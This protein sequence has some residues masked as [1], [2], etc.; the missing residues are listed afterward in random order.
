MLLGSANGT[1]PTPTLRKLPVVVLKTPDGHIIN[2]NGKHLAQPPESHP[3]KPNTDPNE[4]GA[5]AH[6]QPESHAANVQGNALAQQ[7]S[8]AQTLHDMDGPL[9]STS[10]SNSTLTRTPFRKS[11]PD[12]SQATLPSQEA[13]SAT[14]ATTPGPTTPSATQTP[15]LSAALASSR[16]AF[17]T[18]L[19][20]LRMIGRAVGQTGIDATE[21]GKV[22]L[23]DL[24]TWMSFNRDAFADPSWLLSLSGSDPGQP[25]DFGP[26]NLLHARD[27]EVHR[28]GMAL[29]NTSNEDFIIRDAVIL[30]P[31]PDFTI[32]PGP[33]NH[34]LVKAMSGSYIP[35]NAHVGQRNA[36]GRVDATLCVLLDKVSPP[37]AADAPT[38]HKR[39]PLLVMQSIKILYTDGMSLSALA[40][41]FVPQR[42]QLA[43]TSETP[44]DRIWESPPPPASND[45]RFWLQNNHATISAERIDSLLEMPVVPDVGPMPK[46]ASRLPLDRHTFS[47]HF[48]TSLRYEKSAIETIYR[49]CT[50]FDP[51]FTPYAR[52]APGEMPDPW[53]RS[54]WKLKVPGIAEGRPPLQRGNPVW[55][56][57]LVPMDLVND[58]GEIVYDFW[59]LRGH[60]AGLV[61]AS[62][63]V[64]L[65]LPMDLPD[66]LE[67]IVIFPVPPD[68][69]SAH[70]KAL[71][72]VESSS[73]S[74]NED[75]QGLRSFLF[76]R[77]SD[78]NMLPPNVPLGP[79]TLTSKFLDP[80]LNLDQQMAVE[81]GVRGDYGD[82]VFAINGGPGT[83]KT[84]TA[85]EFVRQTIAMH[86][87]ARII[88]AAPS[89]SACDTIT[90]RL[91]KHVSRDEMV[92]INHPE[93]R[94]SDEVHPDIKDYCYTVKND[95]YEIP[96]LD[97]L[98]KKRIIVVTCNDA[99]YL[100]SL[101][102][103]NK[104]L[105]ELCPA[106]KAAPHSLYHW[107]HLVVDEAGQATEPET[108]LAMS[109][110]VDSTP[111]ITRQAKVV[112]CG[113]PNQ[114]GPIIHSQPAR[115]R[116]LHTSLLERL[117]TTCA[118]YRPTTSGRLDLR[119]AS[120]AADPR[121]I[122]QGLRVRPTCAPLTCNYRSHPTMLAVPSGLY[123]NDSLRPVAPAHVTD[124]VIRQGWSG[125]P[126]PNI[127]MTF[128]DVAGKN[129]AVAELYVGDG[130]TGWWNRKELNQVARAARRIVSEGIASIPEIGIMA[131]TKEQVK[132]IRKVLRKW[133]LGDM[134]VGTVQDYQGQEY[135]V[136]ILS[137]VR[138]R[139]GDVL[140]ED[141]DH[142][143]GVINHPKRFNVAVTRAQALLVVVGSAQT[144]VDHDEAW[145][146][147][148]GFLHRVGA[149]QASEPYLLPPQ[150]VN[151]LLLHNCGHASSRSRALG[152]CG[153]GTVNHTAFAGSSSSSNSEHP[154]LDLSQHPKQS[155][156]NI[157]TPLGPSQAT[158]PITS[159]DTVTSATRF[160][161]A[162]Q[163]RRLLLGNAAGPRHTDAAMR[164][165]DMQL[166]LEIV[167][168]EQR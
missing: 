87:H 32:H 6:R 5:P 128:I 84:K 66:D 140:Q 127:P 42:L 75:M 163:P 34:Q 160:T 111:A 37:T 22:I 95:M 98:L 40:A 122:H 81:R 123:Y 142:N 55:V 148:I 114:L 27:D 83:G 33:H 107:T 50:L 79:V 56:R 103:S 76:P 100:L 96:P 53:G 12:K 9:L 120:T 14:S 94:L 39:Q 1:T 99:G 164:M 166:A 144:L 19:G 152:Y 20:H 45:R 129:D 133:N 145:R 73:A 7:N 143:V 109:L 134:N 149:V 153:Q 30:P 159:V 74:E 24:G 151:T 31:H 11:A 4:K 131:A 61:R 125:L 88:V 28:K 46:G 63:Q 36:A 150:W 138:A 115:A 112:L 57:M 157:T 106:D 35:I 49:D 147:F 78:C 86:P 156:K 23:A 16:D 126:N 117:T 167:E 105:R 77:E 85:T 137:C 69:F 51:V 135:K 2:L 89:N 162:T 68:H 21:E 101:G 132:R 70:R 116:N 60:V 110:L 168:Y 158:C 119:I 64:V 141:M 47:L 10:T 124:A 104:D 62:G 43:A 90:R 80:F 136:I 108:L 65:S 161:S 102:L 3:A 91:A 92:R 54:L 18:L 58:V 130:R 48:N 25:L 17:L 41:K 113:D 44:P 139:G 15:N 71:L 154:A 72:A 93:H 26:V 29:L 118:M 13:S 82:V 121:V 97:A 146:E 165:I 38:Y 67:K 59:E 52:G 155:G 8:H